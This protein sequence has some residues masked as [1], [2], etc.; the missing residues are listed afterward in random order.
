VE[1]LNI[2]VLSGSSV[3]ENLFSYS[4]PLLLLSEWEIGARWRLFL[5]SCARVFSALESR[6]VVCYKKKQSLYFQPA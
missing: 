1:S 2:Q 5:L 3:K 4:S 6:I